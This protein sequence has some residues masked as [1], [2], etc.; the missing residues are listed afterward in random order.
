MYRNHFKRVL[1]FALSLSGFIILLPFFFFIIS[2]LFIFNNGFPFYIQK[3]V[4]KD[5]K[6]FNLIKF[7]TMTDK[8]DSNG[9]LLPDVKRI[10][11]LG[12]FMRQYSLDEFPQIINV[13]KGDMSLIG[14]RPL[15]VKYLPLYNTYQLKRHDV[16]PGMTGW[17]AV[18]GRNELTWEEKFKLDV[19][20]V[21]HLS[22]LLDIKIMCITF[23]KVIQSHGIN[24]S[25]DVVMQPFTG[26]NRQKS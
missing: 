6:I 17:A 7:K 4:G 8:R 19:W 16:R 9:N 26:N 1:D 20:Y 14:P 18:N 25:D 3:R 2:L 15:L 12:R 10:T 24:S 21:D 13:I 22:F 5:G 11:A 23:L